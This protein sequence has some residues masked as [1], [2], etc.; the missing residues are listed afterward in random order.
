MAASTEMVPDDPDLAVPGPE[1]GLP[2]NRDL[3]PRHQWLMAAQKVR[4]EVHAEG[5]DAGN[6]EE[7]E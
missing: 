4:E 3:S 1:C 2:L 6:P 5:P 7:V